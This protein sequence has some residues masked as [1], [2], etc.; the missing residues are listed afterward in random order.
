MARKVGRYKVSE[1]TKR[2]VD[3]IVFDSML[4]ANHYAWLKKNFKG[5]LHLQPEFLLQPKFRNVDGKVIQPI[6]YKADFLLG[7]PRL[8]IEDPLDEVNVVIDSKGHLTEVFR[9]KSK[10]FQFRYDNKLWTA[11]NY[12][13]LEAAVR[14][15]EKLIQ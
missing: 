7:P 12:K 1:K 5:E 3:G 11:K 14:H 6:K 8:D 9:I 10:M 13:E 2:T 4:E 15:Y